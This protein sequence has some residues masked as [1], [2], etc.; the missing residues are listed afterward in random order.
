M[1]KTA[2]VGL[3]CHMN[4]YLQAGIYGTEIGSKVC[5]KPLFC[6]KSSPKKNFI[7]GYFTKN[8]LLKKPLFSKEPAGGPEG[9]IKRP[10]REDYIS[11]HVQFDQNLLLFVLGMNFIF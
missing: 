3:S 2:K 7:F 9:T 8:S 11:F 5:K 4:I 1:M 6:L 10:D